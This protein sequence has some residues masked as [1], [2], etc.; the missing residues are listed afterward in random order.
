MA[1]IGTYACSA[2]ALGAAF[3]IIFVD[4]KNNKKDE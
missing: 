2:V 1:L 3:A 4:R